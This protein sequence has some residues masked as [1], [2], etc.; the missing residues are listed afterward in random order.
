MIWGTLRCQAEERVT[1]RASGEHGIDQVMVVCG[2]M[3]ERKG[4]EE[5]GTARHV[6]EARTLASFSATETHW[7]ALGKEQ[8]QSDLAFVW[9]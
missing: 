7:V 8:T 9:S 6:L 5:C 4:V 3:I 1:A 2:G